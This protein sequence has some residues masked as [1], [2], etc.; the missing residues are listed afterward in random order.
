LVRLGNRIPQPVE[1]GYHLCYGDAGHRHFKEPE[2]TRLLVETADALATRLSRP[3]Q[4]IHLPVPRD[5]ADEPYFSALRTLRLPPE[6]QLYLGL[7]HHTDGV[8]GTRRR[9]AV[10][11]R[12]WPDFGVA[13]ECGLG[14]RPPETILELL[15]IHARVAGESSATETD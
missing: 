1:L 7:V 11:E 9:I 2:D 5:R 13:T 10:A 4:W 3:L 12:V 6:T 8:E 14:R 15:R